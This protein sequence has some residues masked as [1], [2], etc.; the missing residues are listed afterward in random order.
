[1][2]TLLKR[3]LVAELILGIT[4]AMVLPFVD[5]GD[6]RVFAPIAALLPVGLCVAFWRRAPLAY[7]ALTTYCMVLA[8]IG[9]AFVLLQLVTIQSL[10]LTPT[11][12]FLMIESALA[13]ALLL[14]LRS[15]STRRWYIR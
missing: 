7:V 11:T 8:A 10:I 6:W 5:T 4:L 3:L 1:M 14:V 12:V 13:V 9:V 2:P 15:T